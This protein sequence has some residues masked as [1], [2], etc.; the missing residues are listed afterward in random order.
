MDTQGRFATAAG[1]T[2]DNGPRSERARQGVTHDADALVDRLH[3]LRIIL[4]AMAQETAT[5]KRE[6]ARLRSENARLHGRVAE[7]E[8]LLGS[9]EPA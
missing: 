8:R 5:A 2:A 6:A 9:A 3:K 1:L 4:P 7:L